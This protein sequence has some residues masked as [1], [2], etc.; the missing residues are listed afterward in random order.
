[1]PTRDDIKRIAT[2]VSKQ[3]ADS[4]K[5][6]EA[7]WAGYRHLVMSPDAP[8]DQ[9]EECRF[10]FMAGAQHLFSSI[11][12]VLDPGDEEPTAADLNKM[13]LIDKELRA[14]AIEIQKRVTRTKGSA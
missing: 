7:G 8:P 6:I 4:G 9:I 12:T 1:M 13:D 3:L 2:E 14:F 10:A 11:M 5:L